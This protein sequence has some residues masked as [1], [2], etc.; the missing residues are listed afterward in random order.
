MTNQDSTFKSTD[1]VTDA[2]FID[3]EPPALDEDVSAETRATIR[4]RPWFVYFFGFLLT[5]AA[6]VVLAI[7]AIPWLKDRIFS[8]SEPTIDSTTIVNSFDDVAELATEEY[9]FT[10]VGKFSDGGKKLLGWN[11]PLT[12]KSFLLTYSGQVT[13][14]ITDIDEA[15]VTINDDAEQVLVTVPAP[16]VLSAAI[17]PGTVEVYDQS[18]N[19]LNQFSVDDVTG[20][21][22]SETDKNR[23]DAIRGGLLEK[24]EDHAETLIISN[25]EAVLLGT[26]QADYEVIVRFDEAGK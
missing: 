18:F 2:D 6:L 14:G 4:K 10:G 16:G 26:E 19:P 8:D 17:D 9:N 20:F 21:L 3:D 12:G 25:V 24:A 7:M 15:R 1:A 5:L 22:A 13:A 11:V 23:D